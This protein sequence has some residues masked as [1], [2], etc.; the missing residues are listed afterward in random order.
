MIDYLKKWMYINDIK[1]DNLILVANIIEQ[2]N[3]K[4][5]IFTSKWEVLY[6]FWLLKK[7]DINYEQFMLFNEIWYNWIN[8]KKLLLI[9]KINWF[10]A[11]FYVK[12]KYFLNSNNWNIL[13]FDKKYK[14]L[15]KKYW[16][17]NVY[18]V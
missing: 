17:N 13:I 4:P 18:Y 3:K 8:D 1:N 14:S 9:N 2:K 15:S 6:Y 10:D 12:Q 16:L 11:I 7:W 5:E